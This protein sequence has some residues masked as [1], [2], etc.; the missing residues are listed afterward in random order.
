MIAGECDSF[1]T[2]DFLARSV[3]GTDRVNP[4]G[5]P[6]FAFRFRTHSKDE[7]EAIKKNKTVLWYVR[8]AANENN[9]MNFVAKSSVKA[10]VATDWQ[11]KTH[12]HRS[13]EIS[14]FSNGHMSTNLTVSK[15]SAIL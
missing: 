5:L 10:W 15:E 11:L 4:T 13:V 12:D 2:T 14:A 6:S 1:I 8:E 3:Q 7:E 9:A